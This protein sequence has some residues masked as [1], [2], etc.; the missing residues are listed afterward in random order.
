MAST[1]ILAI[2]PG[3]VRLGF[4]IS[5]AD[6]KI[7]SPLS[8]YTRG[9]LDQDS[10][11]IRKLV[12]EE[13]VGLI[14]MGLPV[15][16][17]GIEGE[18]ARL[19]RELGKRVQEWTGL[20]LIFWDERFTTFDAESALW[21]A[22]LSH[23]RRKARRDRVAAQILLQTYLDAGCPEKGPFPGEQGT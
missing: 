14:L 8:T 12:E 2:D 4:A 3:K 7:S 22:G 5:D 13:Q 18:Q 10:R 6:R 11:Y 21:E 16:L 20:P 23:K 19:A 1:R 9:S 17:S 15:H